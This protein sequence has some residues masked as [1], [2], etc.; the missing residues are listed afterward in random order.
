MLTQLTDRAPVIIEPTRPADCGG[1]GAPNGGY[2][3][4]G[5]Y[6]SLLLPYQAFVIAFRPFSAQGV[7]GMAGYDS[8]AGGYGVAG[9]YSS[10]SLITAG[11]SDAAI[12]AAVD[13]VKPAGTIVWVRIAS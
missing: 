5:A 9:G 12:F 11:V 3:V 7:A 8:P 1:Y 13:A 4:A 2:G 10:L 6:G